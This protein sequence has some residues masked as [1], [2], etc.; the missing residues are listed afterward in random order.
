MAQPATRVICGMRTLVAIAV[1]IT[2]V[3]VSSEPWLAL[4]I[5]NTA[6]IVPKAIMLNSKMDSQ[7]PYFSNVGS[8]KLDQIS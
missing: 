8:D 7:Q 6:M 4:Y 1:P 2:W 5:S 3:C